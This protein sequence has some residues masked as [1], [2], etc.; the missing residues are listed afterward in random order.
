MFG[1][2]HTSGDHT[3][4]KS[5]S[6]IGQWWQMI[7]STG[8]FGSNTDQVLHSSVGTWWWWCNCTKVRKIFARKFEENIHKN[9]LCPE[10]K[11]SPHTNKIPCKK[12]QSQGGGGKWNEAWMKS[13]C[14]AATNKE[15][16]T[17]QEGSWSVSWIR[18]TALRKMSKTGK[19]GWPWQGGTFQ[20]ACTS[21]FTF[22]K[23]HQYSVETRATYFLDVTL[24]P[25]PLHKRSFNS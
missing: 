16:E 3:L 25:C 11:I 22:R 12:W 9:F 18:R 1:D 2:H 14:L 19:W 21:S 13:S 15:Y 24:S 7:S 6:W 17:V 23:C 4:V 8:P 10:N 20:W 5:E